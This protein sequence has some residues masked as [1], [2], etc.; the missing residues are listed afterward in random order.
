MFASSESKD[1]WFH[2]TPE[3]SNVNTVAWT[4][5]PD[6]G[7]RFPVDGPIGYGWRLGLQIDAKGLSGVGSPTGKAN[8]VVDGTHNLGSVPLANGTAFTFVTADLRPGPHEFLVTYAGDQSFQSSQT[9]TSVVVRKGTVPI[10]FVD[11]A[12]NVVTE[13]TPVLL[14]ITVYGKAERSDGH[15]RSHRQRK[16]DCRT[17]RALEPGVPWRAW[18]HGRASYLQN[19]LSRRL[20]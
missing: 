8:I 2:V 16:K 3:P 14:L 11:T 6:S 13:G 12:P 17:D 10:E 15:G 1:V 18:R 19:Y 7:I 4:S 20:P 5:V 9:R